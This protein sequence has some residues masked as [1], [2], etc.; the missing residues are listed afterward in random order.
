MITSDEPI[1]SVLARA[2]QFKNPPVPVIPRLRKVLDA[3]GAEFPAKN[4]DDFIF[5]GERRGFALDLHNLSQRVIKPL[6]GDV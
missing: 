3:Y 2:K 5:R 1:S 6:I 4:R